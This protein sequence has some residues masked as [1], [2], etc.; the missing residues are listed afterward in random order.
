MN[1]HCVY[2]LNDAFPPIIDGV[3]NAVENYASELY[4][5]GDSPVVL[6]PKTG[7]TDDS[8]YPYPVVRYPSIDQT[9]RIGYY[10][11]VPLSSRISKI[12]LQS[13]PTILH[14]HC[15]AISLF[16]ARSIRVQKKAPLIFTYHSKYDVN[17][18]EAIRGKFIQ[19][20]VIRA[21]VETIAAA[22]EV[23]AVSKG[24]GES[25]KSLGYKGDYVVMENGVDV[26]KGRA[27]ERTIAELRQKYALPEN[28]PVFLFVGRMEWYKNQR[29]ILDALKKLKATGRPFRMLF[30][31]KG[32]EM[33]EIRAYAGELGL[34][35]D[36]VFT[37]AV[38]DRELLRAYYSVAD[39]FLFPS[40]YDTNGLVVREAAASSLPSVL[41]KGSCAAENTVDGRNAFLIDENA[42][43]LYA[44]LDRLYDKRDGIREVG[45]NAADD[46]YVSWHDS[47]SRA[48]ERYGIVEEA[49]LQGKYSKRKA[50]DQTL[51]MRRRIIE[52]FDNVGHEGKDAP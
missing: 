18:R 34:R 12:T 33:E 14:A 51:E 48:K 30:V 24:A 44:M 16:L 20:A 4:G 43:S 26:P 8:I 28:V 25:L 42:D 31:G 41:V 3:S 39:L 27:D 38:T 13:P 21:M 35:D 22:D 52:F 17:I 15:P 29:I 5:F 46:L 2:L 10:V 11:G 23:W 36:T 40:V 6:T 37:G 47:V 7:K 50:K 32:T 9:K 49:Y 19:N 45:E 1:G